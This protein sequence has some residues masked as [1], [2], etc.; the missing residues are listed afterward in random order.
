VIPVPKNKE[1]SATV[2]CLLSQIHCSF[3]YSALASFRDGDVGVSIFPGT[4]GLSRG[5]RATADLSRVSV[6]GLKARPRVK[7]E[8]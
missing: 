3:A 4:G 8:G 2:S 6:K 1:T 7:R 5:R